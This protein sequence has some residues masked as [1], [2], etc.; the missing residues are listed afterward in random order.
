VLVKDVPDPHAAQAWSDM[1]ELAMEVLG[2]RGKKRW[3][4]QLLEQY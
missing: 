3:P 4:L 1:L 2:E